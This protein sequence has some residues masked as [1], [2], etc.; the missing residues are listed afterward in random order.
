MTDVGKLL[1][2]I[3]AEFSAAG[4]REQRLKAERVQAF[5]DRQQ[6]LEQFSQ[7]LDKL[8]E[9][10]RPRLD[11]LATKFGEQVD[12]KPSVEPGKRSATFAFQSKLAR[13]R[14]TFSVAPDADVRNLVFSCDLDIMPILMKF[15]KHDEIA[16]PLGSVDEA[17]L[18]EW[19]DDR[20]V[21]F[22]QTYL[23]LHENQYYLKDHMVEDPIAKIEFPKYA[24]AATLD[25]KGKTYFFIDDATRREFQQKQAD[26]G[27]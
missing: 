26:N 11:A 23:S 2:R 13:I 20:I 4:E 9:V 25:V 6:R 7:T 27:R 16:F 24:A 1:K 15:D 18:A 19:I 17:A 10:W 22:V 5:H 21:Y 3:D 14:L 12:V 8:Q